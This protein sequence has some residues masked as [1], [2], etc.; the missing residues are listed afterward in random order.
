MYLA[1][2]LTHTHTHTQVSKVSCTKLE[3][4]DNLLIQQIA[5][6][7]RS[8]LLKLLFPATSTEEKLPQN[9]GAE[10]EMQVTDV[11]K[12][13][14]LTLGKRLAPTWLRPMQIWVK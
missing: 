9:S 10:Q 7:Q 11:T 1:T 3:G 14:P 5:S 6:E 8:L 4:A 13:R 2:L 12:H